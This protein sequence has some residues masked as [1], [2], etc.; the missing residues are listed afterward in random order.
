MF[1]IGITE[2]PLLGGGWAHKFVHVSPQL[3]IKQILKLQKE[4]QVISQLPPSMQQLNFTDFSLISEEAQA[5]LLKF[6]VIK[7]LGYPWVVDGL[8]LL[9]PMF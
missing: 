7:F 8:S 4:E 1:I 6:T 5:K 3:P 2:M 9:L